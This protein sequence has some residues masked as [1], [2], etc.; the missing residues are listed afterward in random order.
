M[1]HAFTSS[2]TLM[3]H[4]T[5]AA[6]EICEGV[7]GKHFPFIV[8]FDSVSDGNKFKRGEKDEKIYLY[9]FVDF[10]CYMR[11]IFYANI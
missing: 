7:Y 3:C 1:V 9:F 10:S 4:T 5:E 8:T 6:T 11:T 2:W